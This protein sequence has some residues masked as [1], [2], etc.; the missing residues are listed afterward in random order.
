M[1]RAALIVG[2]LLLLVL[3]L[4]LVQQARAQSASVVILDKNKAVISKLVD[5][6]SIQLRLKAQNR[7]AQPTRVTFVLDAETVHVAE[8][9]IQTNAD[10]CETERF[11]ALGWYWDKGGQPKKE[12]AIRA[13]ADGA[14]AAT[15]QVQIAPRP[16]VLA[17]GFI[18]SAEAWAAYLGPNGFLAL[19]GAHGFAVGDGQFEG[20]FNT[21]SI[22]DPA[23]K[24]NTI[25]QNSEILGRYITS[26]KK[27]TGAQQV[28][29]IGHSMGG[30]ISRYYIDRLMQERDV[31]QL[32]MLGTPHN[33]SDC[34][35]LPA[36]LNLYIP[37][38]L[39]IRPSYMRGIFNSQITRRRGVPFHELAGTPIIEAF[40]SPCTD[41]PT[42]VAVSLES[43][44]GIP[45]DLKTMPLLHT[46]LNTSKQVF[47]TFVK[48]LLQKPASEFRS[49]PDPAPTPGSQDALQFTHIYTGHVD[50]SGRQEVTI[51]ID[52][53]AVASFALYD[54]TR[55]LTVTVR[56]AS[57]NVIALDATRNGLIVVDDPS[58]LV[59][60]G[61]GFQNPRP[62]PWRI[63]LQATS[64]TPARGADYAVTAQLRGGATLKARVSTLLPQ[65]NESVDIAARLELA[66]QNL[67]IREAQALVRS[68]DGKLGTISLA[69]SGDEWQVA[70]K[71]VASGVYGINIQ[72]SGSAPDG[73]PLEREAFLSVLAQPAANQVAASQQ[74]IVTILLL[75][76]AGI[77]T[78]ILILAARR[79]AKR[80]T[81]KAS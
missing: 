30:T 21:G 54:P 64:K 80:R 78:I 1:K 75:V 67:P 8:C 43:A 56:G 38:S 28:D 6:D 4:G 20:K 9:T 45:L 24:T 48:P 22:A 23:G 72:V 40:K 68:P 74:R 59:Y 52:Q 35:N 58:T 25:A 60:L 34:A 55:S 7:T 65:P 17:H 27:A 61:Y 10:S 44:Q 62:G 15:T 36:S 13:L 57:G 31:A 5:G 39:E 3:P 26:V 47:E 66:G 51:N 77:T 46:D 49:E 33:G 53:V 12:R 11:A 50:A 69:P 2:L 73:A 81:Q 41:V 29:L 71:P 16:V 70:W 19:M 42:D 63:T 37:A 76:L 18:S 14:V 32:I 79:L